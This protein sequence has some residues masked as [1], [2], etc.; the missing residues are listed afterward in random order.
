M[1]I[2]KSEKN[3]QENLQ[4]WKFEFIKLKFY[5]NLGKNVIGADLIEKVVFSVLFWRKIG[6][7][8]LCSLGRFEPNFGRKVVFIYLGGQNVLL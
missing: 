6:W 7:N 1:E 4:E 5:K 8:L 3:K 2:Y